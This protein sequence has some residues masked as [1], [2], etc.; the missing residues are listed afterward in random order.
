[1]STDY[2]NGWK[3][4]ELAGRVCVKCMLVGCPGEYEQRYI[5]AVDIAEVAARGI[6]CTETGGWQFPVPYRGRV[7]L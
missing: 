4:K 6:W 1:M 3:N 2:R 7:G 5:R